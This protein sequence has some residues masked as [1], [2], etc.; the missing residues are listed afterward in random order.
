MADA[1][2]KQVWSV[3]EAIEY[4]KH[5]VEFKPVFIEG[6]SSTPLVVLVPFANHPLQSPQTRTTSLATRPSARRSSRTAW[7]WPRARRRRT[8]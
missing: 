8:A 2:A 5:L 4:M 3:P 6:G 7:V 1:N